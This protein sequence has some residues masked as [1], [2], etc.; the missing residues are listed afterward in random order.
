[1]ILRDHRPIAPTGAARRDPARRKVEATKKEATAKLLG[2][3]QRIDANGWL[4]PV[5]VVE[6]DDLAI[7]CGPVESG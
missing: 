7:S 5:C 6:V 4:L 2:R 1:M 3:R